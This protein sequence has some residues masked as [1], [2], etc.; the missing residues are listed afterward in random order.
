M[1]I[2]IYVS[3]SELGSYVQIFR[4]ISTVDIIQ[5]K[6]LQ[7]SGHVIAALRLGAGNRAQPLVLP[8]TP[9]QGEIH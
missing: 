1:H 3:V 9:M 7:R 8:Q 5:G 6:C 4:L 2:D